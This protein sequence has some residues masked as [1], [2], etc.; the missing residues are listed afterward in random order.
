MRNFQKRESL[1]FR[2]KC[3]V[4]RMKS[5]GEKPRNEK[6]IASTENR[7]RKKDTKNVHALQCICPAA[8]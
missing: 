4:F 3:G 8:V 7:R 5:E 1:E 2:M 6:C